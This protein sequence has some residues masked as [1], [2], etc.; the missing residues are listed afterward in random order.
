MKSAE[1][2]EENIAHHPAPFSR[3]ETLLISL[4]NIYREIAIL[5]KLFCD[6]IDLTRGSHFV[7]YN[8]ENPQDALQAHM[9]RVVYTGI[10]PEFASTIQGDHLRKP[11]Q[12]RDVIHNNL[13]EMQNALI[14][15]VAASTLHLHLYYDTASAEE[16][17]LINESWSVKDLSAEHVKHFL[18][19]TSKAITKGQTTKPSAILYAIH[20]SDQREIRGLHE[21][22]KALYQFVIAGKFLSKATKTAFLRITGHFITR[23]LKKMGK[24]IPSQGL[25]KAFHPSQDR[26]K[27]FR[28]IQGFES[29]RRKEQRDSKKIPP[30]IKAANAR[31]FD[32]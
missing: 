25:T 28:I 29:I 2:G 32:I 20:W 12:D 27:A 3:Y 31:L 24:T 21:R 1:K 4:R 11:R 6:S 13:P 26:M 5:L 16:E 15:R 17:A 8:M 18:K 7:P 9:M 10:I 19:A 30:H 22:K 14:L 23:A